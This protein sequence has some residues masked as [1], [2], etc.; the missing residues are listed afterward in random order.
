[1][2]DEADDVTIPDV[3]NDPQISAAGAVAKSVTVQTS[4][5]LTINIA[6]VLN[7]N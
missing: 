7:I 3:T 5:Q 1:V 6:G 4:G 2:P